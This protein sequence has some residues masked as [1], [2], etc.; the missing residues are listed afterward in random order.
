MKKTPCVDQQSTFLNSNAVF[1]PMGSPAV[2]LS[3]PATILGVNTDENRLLLSFIVL[4]LSAHNQ[5][6]FNSKILSVPRSL[7]MLLDKAFHCNVQ[8]CEALAACHGAV[9]SDLNHFFPEVWPNK[10]H[11]VNKTHET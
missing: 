6:H 3:I 8:C 9:S 7:N 4:V 11:A 1:P 10:P 2:S 5:R